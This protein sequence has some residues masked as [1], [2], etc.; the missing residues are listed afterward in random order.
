MSWF[1]IHTGDLHRLGLATKTLVMSEGPPNIA[2]PYVR[3]QSLECYD[4]IPASMGPR[5]HPSVTST[6]SPRPL[7][8]QT[9]VCSAAFRAGRAPAVLQTW[10]S[11]DARPLISKQSTK[12]GSAQWDG[13]DHSPGVRQG[14]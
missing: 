13:S 10:L 9:A 5:D 3:G 11:P 12:M 2:M 1:L 14:R 8:R 4:G 7:S 6:C